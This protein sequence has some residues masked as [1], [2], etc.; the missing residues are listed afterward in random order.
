[1]LLVAAVLVGVCSAVAPNEQAIQQYARLLMESYGINRINSSIAYDVAEEQLTY[2]LEHRNET[3]MFTFRETEPMISQCP[4]LAPRT[5][6]TKID[7]LHPQDIRIVAAVGDSVSTGCNSL[8]NTWLNMK[9]YQ[10]ISWS[11]GADAGVTTMPNLLG[12]YADLLGTATGTGDSHKGFNFAQN[13]AIVQD[14]PTQ[15]KD[16]VATLKTHGTL[17][18]NNDWKVVTVLI[19]GNNLCD[20]CIDGK[21]NDN[22]AQA[23]EKHLTDT[24]DILSLM[25]R[26]FVNLV[27]HLDYTQIAKFKGPFCGIALRFV[28]VCLSTTNKE[29]VQ[30]TQAKIAA[31]HA[32]N[33]NLAARY[34]RD[35]F[36]VVGQPSLTKAVIPDRAYITHADCFHPS[37]EGQRLFATAL[38]N[39]MILPREKKNT[40]VADARDLP[41]CANADTRLYVD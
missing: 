40:Y 21:E 39:S 41:Q 29:R 35:D 27:S 7:D 6:P 34:R 12:E 22:N 17:D 28:C 32:V 36:A 37:G 3:E 38:W 16:L 31:Y 15:A 10:G 1:V 5:I 8:S 33:E 13:G 4:K 25:P 11:M 18:F 2:I 24:L 23:Y 26:T 9:D 20:V 30:R 19:G 14:T